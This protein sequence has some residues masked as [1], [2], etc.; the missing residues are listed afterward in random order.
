M[1]KCPICGEDSILRVNYANQFAA[2]AILLIAGLAFC[3]FAPKFPYR[4]EVAEGIGFLAIL[5]L[6]GFVKVPSRKKSYLC[7]SCRHVWD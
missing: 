1:D 5:P 2:T 6:V 7:I 4:N 3:L